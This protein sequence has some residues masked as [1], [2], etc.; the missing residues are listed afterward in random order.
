ML[1]YGIFGKFIIFNLFGKKMMIYKVLFTFQAFHY[2]SWSP[3]NLTF[4]IVVRLIMWSRVTRTFLR[5]QS[6]I[7]RISKRNFWNWNIGWMF[8]PWPRS[9]APE[10][11]KRVR[12]SAPLA[13]GWIFFVCLNL[14]VYVGGPW[15]YCWNPEARVAWLEGRRDIKIEK[16][17][18]EKRV[19]FDV[20]TKK[21]MDNLKLVEQKN[22]NEV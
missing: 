6:Q 13:A 12:W 4:F 1:L 22:Q 17:E 18:E 20:L 8:K 16:Y 2:H 3:A 9:G 7:D 14:H 19:E 11:W 10:Y 5:N 21:R 15:D